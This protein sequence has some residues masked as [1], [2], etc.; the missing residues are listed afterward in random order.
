MTT[1]TLDHLSEPQRQA[2]SG[3]EPATNPFAQLSQRFGI[4]AALARSLGRPVA[5]RTLQGYADLAA[6]LAKPDE[7]E[8]WDVANPDAIVPAALLSPDGRYSCDGCEGLV[9]RAALLS[10]PHGFFCSECAQEQA[11]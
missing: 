1:L 9:D 7:L 8:R 3:P 11:P 5:A 2:L 10:R 6:D 4:Q